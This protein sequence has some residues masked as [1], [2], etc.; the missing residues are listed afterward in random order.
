MRLAELEEDAG[1]HAAKVLVSENVRED[2]VA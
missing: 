2:G 1:L